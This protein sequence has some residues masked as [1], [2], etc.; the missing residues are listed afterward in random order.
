MTK[1]L[2]QC[3]TVPGSPICIVPECSIV[4]FPADFSTMPM[5]QVVEKYETTRLV[6]LNKGQREGKRGK[7]ESSFL[8][9][10]TPRS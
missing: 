8:V 4:Y 7:Q 9:K 5:T 6:V 1:V 2:L 3:T 10:I